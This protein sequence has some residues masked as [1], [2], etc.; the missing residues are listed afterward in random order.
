MIL[1]NSFDPDLRTYKEAKY[2]IQKGFRVQILCWDREGRYPDKETEIIEGI[3]IKRFYPYSQYGTGLKQIVPFIKFVKECRAYIRKIK[4]KYYCHCAD[5]DGMITGFLS[6][7]RARVKLVF[8]MREFYESGSLTRFRYF[9]RLAVRFLQDRCYRIIYLNNLQ[10][11]YVRKRNYNKLV[12]LPNYP[13]STKFKNTEKTKSDK[14]QVS[15]IG[16]VRHEKQLRALMDA[17]ALFRDKIDVHIHGRGVCYDSLKEYAQAYENCFVTGDFNHECID[18]LYQNTDLLFCVYDVRDDNDKHAYPTKFFE[19]IITKTPMIVAAD[20]V[21][22]KFCEKYEIG[23]AINNHYK[24]ALVDIFSR[25]TKSDNLLRR[26]RENEAK[27]QKKYL[28]EQ[29]E[30]NLDTIYQ[31][32][33]E[34][35]KNDSIT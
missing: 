4:G 3:R 6:C 1:T 8:D 28:W 20:T 7:P 24:E 26:M 34:A 29:V 16:Y 21:I 19:A 14:I 27:I 23:F 12:Y 25:I 33:G 10:K 15:F 35:R 2:L 5:L 32:G 17:A 11:K 18:N 31:I 9:V 13:E 22:A 30:K